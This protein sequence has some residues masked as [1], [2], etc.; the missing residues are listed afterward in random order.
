MTDEVKPGSDGQVPQVPP[1]VPGATQPPVEGQPQE[2]PKE[3]EPQFVTSEQLDSRIEETV[4][5]LRKADKQ[6]VKQAKEELQAQIKRLEAIG[7]QTTPEQQ[8]KLEDQIVSDLDSDQEPQQEY[9]VSDIP[10]P[11]RSSIEM[12]QAADVIIKE[13]DPEFKEF[14][15]PFVDNPGPDLLLKTAKAIEAKQA[16]IK[17][18]RDKANLRTPVGGGGGPGQEPAKSAMDYFKRAHPQK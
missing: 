3:Q 2:P 12:M 9:D 15:E 11:I 17:L 10:P 16:R 6:R 13:A 14:I 4:L 7:V 1:E 5:K 18:Q 8:Q